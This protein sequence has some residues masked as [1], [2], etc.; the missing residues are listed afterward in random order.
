MRLLF[1]VRTRTVHDRKDRKRRRAAKPDTSLGRRR[2]P[3]PCP[4]R[5]RWCETDAPFKHRTVTLIPYLQKL[6][7]KKK[8]IQEISLNSEDSPIR[9][10]AGGARQNGISA[11]PM[12]GIFFATKSAPSGFSDCS[13]LLQC[14]VFFA[15][16]V[17]SRKS[18]SVLSG[19]FSAAVRC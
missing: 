6:Y 13:L 9:S 1:R 12:P 18:W 2:R 14:V 19:D 5:N 8:E 3:I 10:L 4:R 15:P 16:K 7:K 17:T 11:R